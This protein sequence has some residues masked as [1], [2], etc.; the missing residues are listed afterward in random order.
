FAR[1]AAQPKP[2]AKPAASTAIKRTAGTVAP[3]RRAPQTR[4]AADTPALT[5]TGHA[6]K[7]ACCCSHHAPRPKANTN[8][9][10]AT[11]LPE[12]AWNAGLI[13]ARRADRHPPL[14]LGPPRKANDHARI[15]V[16]T[17]PS[18]VKLP[19]TRRPRS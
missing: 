17:V 10:I 11:A 12:C 2:S 19:L 5:T 16:G 9:G 7:V 15:T 13:R 1:P 14:F 3:Y 6:G 8:A 18:M 4:S